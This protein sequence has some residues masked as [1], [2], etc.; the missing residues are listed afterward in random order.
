[1]KIIKVVLL[2]CILF[3]SFANANEDDSGVLLGIQLGYAG[4]EYDGSAKT[5]IT[6][7][8]INNSSSGISY[9][10]LLGYQHF[11]NDTH[12]LR[13]YVDYVISSAGNYCVNFYCKNAYYN[14]YGLALDYLFN[15]KNDAFN[16]YGIFVGASYDYAS[17][18]K[19]DFGTL[20]DM[21]GGGLGAN[22][23]FRYAYQKMSL[24]FG[25]KYHFFK[26]EKD[27]G[28]SI[29]YDSAKE[30]MMPT[31]NVFLRANYTF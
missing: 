29:L 8:S 10:F 20:E 7:L 24:E 16:S 23:G 14:T 25:I 5:N 17:F 18:D 21:K 9:G 6:E 12:G 28:S 27:Y 1:M 15:F 22:V 31:Y 4:M 26:L 19:S 2:S 13:A 3:F 30:S 11:F